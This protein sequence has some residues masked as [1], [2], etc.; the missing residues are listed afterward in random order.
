MTALN[1]RS[2]FSHPVGD[3]YLPKTSPEGA[4]RDLF[5][6]VSRRVGVSSEC[7][8]D[9]DRILSPFLHLPV[10]VVALPTLESLQVYLPFLICSSASE[11][12]TSF[13][14]RSATLP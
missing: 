8:G 13:S 10:R 6:D 9:D 5:A 7:L 11:S 12:P 4:T 2:D 14:F 3:R 1:W